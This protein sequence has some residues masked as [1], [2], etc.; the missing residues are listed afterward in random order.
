[1]IKAIIFDLQGT[2]FSSISQLAP[3]AKEL[4]EFAKSNSIKMAGVTSGT[5]DETILKHLG[6]PE[7]LQEIKMVSGTGKTVDV[8]DAMLSTLGVSATEAIGIGDSRAQEIRCMNMLGGTTIWLHGGRPASP[9]VNPDE[10]ADHQVKGLVEA[11]AVVKQLVESQEEQ[12]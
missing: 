3:G 12:N 7:Y 6:L 11:L 1:M 9:S 10:N 8:F 5:Y 4:F 2:L